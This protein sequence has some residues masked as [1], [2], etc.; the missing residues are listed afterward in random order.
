MDPKSFFEDR[1]EDI[2]SVP[3]SKAAIFGHF[4]LSN[5]LPEEEVVEEFPEYAMSAN[6]GGGQDESR[7]HSLGSYT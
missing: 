4:V 2:Q 5:R 3:W 7:I 1:Y 6:Q